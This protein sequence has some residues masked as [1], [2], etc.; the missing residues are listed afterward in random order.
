MT[1]DQARLSKLP[2]TDR[3]LAH[4][5]VAMVTTRVGATVA[6]ALV[7][8]ALAAAR[9]EVHAGGDAP[10]EEEVAARVC[11]L[12]DAWLSRRTARVI[13]A[14]GVVLHT[15]LGRAPLGE[16]ARAALGAPGY[17]SLE[18]DLVTGERGGRAAFVESALATLTGAEAALVVNNNAAAVL[19][20]LGSI[21]AG[22]A[23]IVS[24]GE[25]VEIGGGFRVP[26][27]IARSGARLVEVGT[28]NR[29]RVADFAHALDEHAD[30]AAILRVHPGNFKQT[31]F[32]ERPTLSEL[33]ALGRARKVRVVED[34]GGGA[35]VPLPGLSGDPLV[36]ESVAAG[37]DVVTFS[38]DKILGGPQG[39]VLVG[40]RDSV[41]LARRDPLHRA[42]RLGRL[43]LV[44]LEVTLAAYLAG[45][46]DEI[47]SVAMV[48]RTPDEL[49][50]RARGWA[51]S[52]PGTG[53][54]VVAVA[55][56]A[57]G[58]TYAEEKI[59]SFGL[60][61]KGVDPD[62]LAAKLRRAPVPVLARIEG[63]AV[64]LDARTVLPDEDAA[65][66]DTIRCALASPD[67]ARAISGGDDADVAGDARL[68]LADDRSRGD[69]PGT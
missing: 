9:R 18:M 63:G 13:N 15:N 11:A 53:A 19:L 45:D 67:L 35:L 4:P 21:A 44:A 28:T 54:E 36:S 23:V 68:E 40:T 2:R 50:A 61:L 27:V 16:A 12:V 37:A 47:P 17:L 6:K 8:E 22:R 69:A 57:G 65:L 43:P 60:A 49:E 31:G 1:S 3:L 58:G 38:T 33:V 62:A 14:T 41:A 34:L 5:R 29:T 52:L 56:V 26:E 30:A 32:V 10:G 42:L 64:V 59:P 51:V 48:R 55:S 24:R 20:A 25:L 39:G 66:L 7:R 46:L